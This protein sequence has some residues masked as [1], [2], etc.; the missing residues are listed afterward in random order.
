[1][2]SALLAILLIFAFV[3]SACEARPQAPAA[4]AQRPIPRRLKRLPRR[5]SQQRYYARPHAGDMV[6]AGV[7]PG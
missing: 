7:L 6:T 5:R 2:F 1:M 4:T 3:V